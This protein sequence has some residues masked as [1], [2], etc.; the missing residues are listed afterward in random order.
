MPELIAQ[1][2]RGQQAAFTTIYDRH[3]GAIFYYVKKFVEDIHQA[4]DITAETFIKLW[5]RR[6]NF[7][8]EKTIVSFLHTTARN[9]SI[10]WLRAEKR[11]T[12]NKD[13]LLHL[14]E[15]ETFTAS[16]EEVKAELL[17]LVG[18]EIEKLPKKIKQVF[19]LAY[20]EG[21]SN[22][23]IAA[24]LHINNQSVR[25]HK[26][27]AIKLLRLAISGRIWLFL[28]LCLFYKRFS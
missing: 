22:E 18:Q 23:E 1:F 11:Q 7:P 3:W 21:K 8:N 10:D 6:E 28:L 27:R 15:N 17:R 13:Q 4:E 20:I 24:E 5:Q 12:A 9:A 2:N 25:N 16:Q 14:L 19:K 26:S